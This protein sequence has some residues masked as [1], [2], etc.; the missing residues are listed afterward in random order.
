MRLAFDGVASTLFSA[1]ILTE[2]LL[3]D[4]IPL[5]V[6]DSAI[7][8]G[9][10]RLASETTHDIFREK[11]GHYWV[12]REEGKDWQGLFRSET[13][14]WRAQLL[15][16][17]PA[18]GESSPANGAPNADTVM[19]IL[20]PISGAE[21]AANET[22]ADEHTSPRHG[23]PERYTRLFD[24]ISKKFGSSSD[25]GFS[26]AFRRAEARRLE[27]ERELRKSLVQQLSDG[28]DQNLESLC[29]LDLLV[30]FRSY[31]ERSFEAIGAECVELFRDVDAFQS[32]LYVV[33]EWVTKGILPTPS[34]PQ[35]T[36]DRLMALADH[37]AELIERTGTRDLMGGDWIAALDDARE[38]L[39]RASLQGTDLDAEAVSSEE[40]NIRLRESLSAFRQRIGEHDPDTLLL[41]GGDWER[42][43]DVVL[44]DLIRTE[45]DC[46]VTLSGKSFLL[47]LRNEANRDSAEQFLMVALE[48]LN[49]V[50][51]ASWWEQSAAS[52]SGNPAGADRTE[53]AH[54][55]GVNRPAVVLGTA[56]LPH[57]RPAESVFAADPKI[58]KLVETDPK[59]VPHVN[60]IAQFQ[61]AQAEAEVAF[62]QR[63]LTENWAEWSGPY[64]WA[65]EKDPDTTDC[66]WWVAGAEYVFHLAAAWRKHSPGNKENVGRLLPEQVASLANWFYNSRL[67]AHDIVEGKNPYA[68]DLLGGGNARRFSNV[69][70]LFAMQKFAESDL[71]E[72]REREALL[73]AALNDLKGGRPNEPASSPP[74]GIPD[75]LAPA[76]GNT[77]SETADD[78]NAPS[79]ALDP[80]PPRRTPDL[81]SSR[82]RLDLVNALARELATIKQDL[83]RFCTAEDLKQKHPQFILWEHIDKAE[84]K[85]LADGVAFAPKAYAENLTLRK[86]GI[87]SRE[88][89]KKDRKKL[90]QAQKPVRP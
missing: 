8:A 84:L 54:I 81:Q 82:N 61:Q 66:P 18:P 44:A 85:E 73:G 20:T 67:L 11:L 24:Y 36:I 22:A 2:Q 76:L 45:A 26:T 17:P 75:P 4:Q 10:W 34:T 86:F 16:H 48:Q 6:W 55:A 83:K 49:G 69:A 60:L 52:P 79:C 1:G 40:P 46:A 89:L 32:F 41:M 27:A 57:G 38:N 74:V 63:E 90:R 19:D 71:N 72:W 80:T 58:R 14:K 31:A 68:D 88:T 64:P 33:M 21:E 42:M 77:S 25:G 56:G 30:H 7:A 39:R 13:A 87:T 3:R 37:T 65:E 47:A 12:W 5:F 28:S 62:R 70:F 50:L 51:V 29:P 53:S 78:A 9:W 59:I 15:E 23:L 35:E 43:I